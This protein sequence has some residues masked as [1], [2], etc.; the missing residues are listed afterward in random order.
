MTGNTSWDPDFGFGLI[1]S[2]QKSGTISGVSQQGVLGISQNLG[3]I[4]YGDQA[5]RMASL[6]GLN[7]DEIDFLTLKHSR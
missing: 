1:V 3:T 6:T 5:G 4:V 7:P 2:D